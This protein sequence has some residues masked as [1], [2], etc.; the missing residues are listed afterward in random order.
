MAWRPETPDTTILA[1]D[2]LNF[3]VRAVDLQQDTLSYLWTLNG[4]RIGADTAISIAFADTGLYAVKCLISD[5]AHSD[6]VQWSVQ[7]TDLYIS[8]WTPDSLDFPV[9]RGSDLQFSVFVRATP[10]DPVNINW[11]LDNQLQGNR[12]SVI[13]SFNEPGAHVV[14]AAAFRD[15][16]R[17][18]VVWNTEVRSTVLRYS[19][20]PRIQT[21]PRDTTAVFYVMP[22]NPASDSLSYLWSCDGD[23]VGS[24]QAV[25]LTF[26]ELGD[27]EVG[28]FARDGGEVD[29]LIWDILIVDS[30]Q[31]TPPEALGQAGTP[32]LL[33]PVPNP[34]NQAFTVRFALPQ[35]GAIG[36]A[37]HDITGR[38]VK[39]IAGGN[40]SSGFH[41][42]SW[43]AAGIPAGIYLLRLTSP[44]GIRIVKCVKLP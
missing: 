16:S 23:S 34:F 12:E 6:S 33:G 37:I 21:W 39:E 28:V 36:L 25:R 17:D 10:G 14:R 20:T 32:V 9:R 3:W 19:P 24:H 30:T 40:W 26:G 7:A 4:E 1:G 8:D 22:F 2:T 5:G 38:K 35:P 43:D 27:H 29:E 31:A 18:S 11:L 15:E 41:T 13:I 42:V 44:W